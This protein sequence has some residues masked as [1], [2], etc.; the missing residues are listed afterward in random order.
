MSYVRKF[1]DYDIV[2]QPD[3]HE[4]NRIWM[5]IESRN[6][7]FRESG[8]VYGPNFIER[9]RGITWQ[10]KLAK[11]EKELFREVLKRQKNEEVNSDTLKAEINKFLKDD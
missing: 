9:W 3:D 1:K 6:G 10:D 7:S 11:K 2:V 4:P 5:K 8:F